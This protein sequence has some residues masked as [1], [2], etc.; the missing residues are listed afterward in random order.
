MTI[1]NETALLRLSEANE[2]KQGYRSKCG[3]SMRLE[4]GDIPGAP[5]PTPIGGRWVLRDAQGQI[6]DYDAFRYDLA[7]RNKLIIQEN[8]TEK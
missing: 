8:S 4:Y 5:R 3:I 1:M 7:E 2:E 6:I